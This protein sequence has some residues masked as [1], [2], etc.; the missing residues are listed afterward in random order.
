LRA[1]DNARMRVIWEAFEIGKMCFGILD[2][3]DGR[4]KS[5]ESPRQVGAGDRTPVPRRK[6]L[7]SND[8]IAILRADF[9]LD[10]PGC[11]PCSHPT[12]SGDRSGQ[13]ELSILSCSKSHLS[14][15]GRPNNSLTRDLQVSWS[16]PSHS[17]DG[18]GTGPSG[19]VRTRT[20][21]TPGRRPKRLECRQGSV[22][23]GSQGRSL[24]PS[25][26]SP[27]PLYSKSDRP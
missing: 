13:S 10:T 2:S 15:L 16:P 12:R 17:R 18:P 27:S 14:K 11:H 4:K 3:A 1:R 20:G 7:F 26:P 22:P 23:R 21:W 25:R 6:S 5:K 24:T 19:G 9:S 8:E